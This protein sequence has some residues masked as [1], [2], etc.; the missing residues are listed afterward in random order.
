MTTYSIEFTDGYFCDIPIIE[1]ALGFAP[2]TISEL[3]FKVD[4]DVSGGYR[5]Q[6]FYQPAE[7]PEIDDVELTG[8]DIYLIDGTMVTADSNQREILNGF[9][10][11]GDDFYWEKVDTNTIDDDF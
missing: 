11:E 8:V 10:P 4:V 7:Y 1:D 9:I 6:T 3:V 5:E 2:D